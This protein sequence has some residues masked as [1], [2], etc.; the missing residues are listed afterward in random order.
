MKPKA[1]G[2]LTYDLAAVLGEG[3]MGTK[4]YRGKHADGR[5]VAVKVMLKSV[6]PEHRAMR[7][8]HLMQNLAEEE[9]RGR[10]HVIAYRCLEEDEGPE[11]RVL[12]G[13]ELCEGGSL[14]DIIVEQKQRIPY[15]HQIRISRELC[16][17]VAFLHQHKIVHRDIR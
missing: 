1:V 3:S 17:A 9:G 4:V 13:M 14:Y 12:L 7:E 10:A 15:A 2:S 11:G 16:E 5:S 8:L 6:A